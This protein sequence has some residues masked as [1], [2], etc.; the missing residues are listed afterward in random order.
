MVLNKQDGTKEGWEH[1]WKVIYQETGK[2]HHWGFAKD[3]VIY[4]VQC[5]KCGMV[6]FYSVPLPCQICK[7]QQLKRLKK[8]LLR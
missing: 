1:E 2:F 4:H 5:K 6:S 7:S 3:E 8:E